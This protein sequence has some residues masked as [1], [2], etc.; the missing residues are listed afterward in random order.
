MFKPNTRVTYSQLGIITLKPKQPHRTGTVTKTYANNICVVHWDDIRTSYRCHSKFLESTDA[1]L[2]PY[3]LHVKL[4][5]SI[6]EAAKI[7]RRQK[8]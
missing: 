1:P 3:R 5:H 6:R 7:R 4:N 2:K 8:T